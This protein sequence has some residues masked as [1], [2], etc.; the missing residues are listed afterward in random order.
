MEDGYFINTLSQSLSFPISILTKKIESKKISLLK[1]Y[2][3]KE[4]YREI[5]KLKSKSILVDDVFQRFYP[6]NSLL[7]KTLG[8]SG[9][10]AIGLYGIEFYYDDFLSFK[11]N[12][13]F[14]NKTL[15]LNISKRLQK[16]IE[17]QLD[18]YLKSIKATKGIVIVQDVETKNIIALV[19]LPHFDINH[20]KQYK[21]T[22]FANEAIS[23]AIEPGS[24]AKIFFTAYL[25]EKKKITLTNQFYCEGYYEINKE[26][27][28]KCSQKHGR[29]NIE[30]IL[31]YSCNT[32][33][34]KA[35]ESLKNKE[36]YQ[37][38]KNLSLGE[39]I[40]IDLPAENTGILP[41]KKNWD[42]RT[43]ALIPIG[44]SINMTPI[45]IINLFSSMISDGILYSPKVARLF[46]WRRSVDHQHETEAIV[47]NPIRPIVS[48]QTVAEIIALLR[49]G[50]DE[51]STGYL[52]Q[53][54]NPFSVIGKTSTSQLISRDHSRSNSVYSTQTIQCNI[55]RS[56]SLRK[57]QVFN[58]GF[59]RRTSKTPLGRKISRSLFC[60]CQ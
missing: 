7:A 8:F 43:R 11:E 18:V 47:S 37:W 19:N 38:L 32:G 52:A 42:L 3:S 16:K 28:I 58:F 22:M 29:V 60:K 34:I 15:H 33:I 1:R 26:E 5:S 12:S 44:H 10:D 59:F 13:D 50:S 21:K 54:N 46:Q 55:C 51:K 30:D 36:I 9:D 35:C 40:G 49:F 14:L 31:R 17:N 56:D 41:A 45:Q 23:S 57:S 25:L 20:F 48:P 24:I 2:A 6:E 27:K 39:K 4:Q 53:K